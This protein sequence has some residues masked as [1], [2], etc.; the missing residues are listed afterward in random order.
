[1]AEAD[2]AAA[3]I[4]LP[5]SIAP[6]GPEEILTVRHL[7]APRAL[8]FEAWTSPEHVGHWWGPDGFTTTTHEMRVAPG[9]RWRFIMHGPDGTDY[10]NRIT[11]QQIVRPER[12]VY[13]HGDDIDDDPEAFHVVVDF[14]ESDG[15]TL[16]VMRARF[17]SAARKRLVEEQYHAIEGARQHV[18]R[19]GQYLDMLQAERGAG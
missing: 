9:G 19:L 14:H 5:A 6:E 8:V 1:M 7:A 13:A 4:A 15:G 18:A 3:H 2:S 10:P 17:T 12:L 11:F 16:L